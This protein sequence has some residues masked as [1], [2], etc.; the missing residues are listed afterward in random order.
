MESPVALTQKQLPE[1]LLE[2]A[3][4]R[5]VFV[6]GSPGIGKSALVEQFAESV[7]MHCETLLGSQL[8]PEDLIGVPQIEGDKSYFRPPANIAREEPYVLFL[9]ELNASSSEIQKAMFSIIHDRRIGAYRLPKGSVIIAAG[10]PSPTSALVKPLAKPLINRFIHVTLEVSHRDWLEW[11]HSEVLSP[12][13]TQYVEDHPKDLWAAIPD[14]EE[15]FSTPRSWHM[16]SDALL[17][18]G[19]DIDEKRVQMLAFGTLTRA[20]ATKFHAFFRNQGTR[21]RVKDL[22]AG[23]IGWPREAADRDTLYILAESLRARLIKELP[24]EKSKLSG[25]PANLAYQ[26]KRLIADLAGIN[27]ELARQL[28][29]T[30]DEG[31][32]LPDWYLVEI[33]REL[34]RLAAKDDKVKA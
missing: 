3:P 18:S 31:H 12:L 17:A 15:P 9:D 14:G 21:Y 33:V 34:P 28:V 22:I 23:E 20:H 5:P 4:V 7:G 2:V 32:K 25:E 8:A 11:A 27:Q 29:S 30:D 13:V 10:N 1:F 26:G 6:W 24:A 16:L 19:D